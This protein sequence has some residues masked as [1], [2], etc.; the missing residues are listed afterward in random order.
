MSKKPKHSRHRVPVLAMTSDPISERYQIEVN[1]STN[2]LEQ[3]YRKAVK[4]LEA[5]ERRA[6]R[7]RRLLT[8]SRSKSRATA[9]HYDRLLLIVEDRRRELREIERLM[10]PTDYAGRDCHRRHIRQ[11]AAA[12]TI[13]LGATTGEH[14]KPLKIP[15][16]P[17]TVTTKGPPPDE[18][19][20]AHRKTGASP[21]HPRSAPQRKREI[22]R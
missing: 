17:V 15:V 11:E 18:R 9:A 7:A 10:M 13:P 2:R 8:E 6:E 4:A 3:R 21:Q 22:P 5:A 12:I 16:Y 14:L 19:A 1:I 20:P